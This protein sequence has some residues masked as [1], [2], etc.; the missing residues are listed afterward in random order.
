MSGPH[1]G[2]P[3][4]MRSCPNQSLPYSWFCGDCEPHWT[5]ARPTPCNA[6]LRCYCPRLGCLGHPS[7][8]QR[9]VAVAPAAVRDQLAALRAVRELVCP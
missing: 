4:T 6:P 9:V 8:S 1:A 3:C 5:A 7:V 2:D